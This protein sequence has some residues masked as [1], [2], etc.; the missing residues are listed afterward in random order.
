[1]INKLIPILLSVL[2]IGASASTAEDHGGPRIVV[3]EVRADLGKVM[4]GTQV[5]HTFEV[6]NSGTEPLIIERVQAD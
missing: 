2:F 1:M 6:H 3:N 5:A 4:Q